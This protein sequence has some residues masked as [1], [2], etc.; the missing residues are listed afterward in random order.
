[1]TKLER[2]SM[3]AGNSQ[4]VGNAEGKLTETRENLCRNRKIM[5][6]VC[7]VR[8]YR[9]FRT[10]CAR[11]SLCVTWTKE[12]RGEGRDDLLEYWRVT[13]YHHW[14]ILDPPL[15]YNLSVT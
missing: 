9:G 10:T 14:E 7:Y 8:A 1:M 2:V 3:L 4:V 12:K 15:R 6:I 11:D 5:K 13:P